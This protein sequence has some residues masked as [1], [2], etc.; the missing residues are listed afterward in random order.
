[1]QRSLD[2]KARAR[3]RNNGGVASDSGRNG[4]SRRLEEGKGLGSDSRYRGEEG[5]FEEE[6]VGEVGANGGQPKK[7][8]QARVT[9]GNAGPSSGPT[10]SRAVGSS[11]STATGTS[12]SGGGVMVIGASG[13]AVTAGSGTDLWTQK[14]SGDRDYL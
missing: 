5:M 1:M 13:A 8:S 11:S 10:L 12:G 6:E 7:F 3:A 9:F 2:A 14:N 4:N